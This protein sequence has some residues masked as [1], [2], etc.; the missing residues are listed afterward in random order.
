M[1]DVRPPW[2]VPLLILGFASLIVGVGAGLLR[3]GWSVPQP[4]AALAAFHG[5]LMVSGFFGTVISLERAVA[6]ARRWAY[7][8][9]LAAG[10]GGLALILGA[11]PA[12]AQVLLALGSA[13]LLAGSV[14]VFLRQRALFTFTLA[15]GAASWLTGNLLWLG[16]FSV[17]E[18]V[19]WWA[20]FL[21][22]TIAGERLELSRFLPPSPIAQ[23][24]FAAVL[25][26][27]TFGMALQAQL[28]G[29]A[30]VALTLWLLRQDIARRTVKEK[31]LTRFI[32]VCLLSGYAWLAVAGTIMLGAGL[33]PG[34][35]AYDAALHAL[36]LGFVFSMVFGHAP[37][38]FPAVLRV[39]V[40]YH[41]LFYAP[42]ALLHLSLLVRLAGDAAS[43]P[44]LR[45]AGGLLN[46]VALAAFILNT[47][48]AVIRGGLRKKAS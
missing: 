2:R 22:L 16:G 37:I 23:R 5:P 3:L 4:A 29:A 39:A 44:E 11:A 14:S 7:L 24:A 9:P 48:A 38:I 12:L 10:A 34:S 35:A 17:Y 19:P 8:G 32:A 45:S 28:F 20:G 42:L 30:L 1:A 36:M 18:V 26:G 41:P 46:A 6:L 47:V 40:P 25:A 15:A 43:M 31:G 13:V 21:V 33:A 27:L